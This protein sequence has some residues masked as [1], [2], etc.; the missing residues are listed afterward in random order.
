MLFIGILHLQSGEDAGFNGWRHGRI[1]PDD[2]AAWGQ[3]SYTWG[4]G[5]RSWACQDLEKLL[6]GHG[7][8]EQDGA[9]RDQM[10]RKRREGFIL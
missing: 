8:F 9:L 2:N 4:A 1:G 10:H 6:F 5:M 7:G 3:R